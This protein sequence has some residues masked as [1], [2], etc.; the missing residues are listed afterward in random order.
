MSGFIGSTE[1]AVY[2]IVEGFETE[3]ASSAGLV[4][5]CGH[6]RIFDVEEGQP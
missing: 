4:P 6:C 1:F 3:G 5:I 2:D